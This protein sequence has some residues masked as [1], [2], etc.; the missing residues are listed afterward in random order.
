MT[1]TPRRLTLPLLAVP[2]LALWTGCGDPPASGDDDGSSTGTT[3]DTGDV[4][5]S[6]EPP[7]TGDETGPP[8]TEH[9]QRYWLHIDDTPPPPVVLEL[10]KEK[11]LEVFG[12]KAARNI[13]LIDVDS[14]PL[15]ADVLGRIQSSCGDK[16]DDYNPNTADTQLP[17]DPQ[18]DCGQ[19]PLGKTFGQTVLEWKQSP[20]YQMVRL[21]TM[22]PRNAQVRGTVMEDMANLFAS[23]DNNFGQLSFQ[24]ALAAIMFCPAKPGETVDACRDKMK[25]NNPNKVELHAQEAALHTRPFI[26]V[27]LLA[28]TL[29]LTLLATH[30]NIANDE[31][32]LAV[33]LYDALKDMQPL[34]EVYGPQGDHPGL[35]MPDDADFT[36]R[37]DALT[38][39]FKMTATAA[40]NLRRVEGIDASVG[41]GEMFLNAIAD[42][43]TTDDVRPPPLAFDFADEQKV[44]F[45]G[46]T[47]VPTVDMR[48]RITELNPGAGPGELVPVPSCE[49]KEFDGDNACMQ[50]VPGNDDPAFAQYVWQQPKWSLE[51]IIAHAAHA[52]YGQRKL[53]LCIIK[54]DPLCYLGAYIGVDTPTK[55]DPDDKNEDPVLDGV[56]DPPGWTYLPGLFQGLTFPAP[57]YFHEMLLNVAQQSLHDFS[58][59]P[60]PNGNTKYADGIPEIDEGDLNPVFALKGVPIGLTAADMIKSIRSELAKQSDYI[61]GVILGKYWKN[62]A[63]LDFYYRRATAVEAGGGAPMLFF[64]GPSDLR[65]S[66]DDP[67]AISNY[68]Y[69]KPGFFADR[70]LT[71]KVSRTDIGGLKDSEHEKYQLQPGEQTLYMQDDEARNYALHF[72]VPDNPDP[73]EI[74]LRIEPL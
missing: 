6:G 16:W 8:T 12:E 66:K 14:G 40:S 22:T 37:S 67:E 34:S 41:A 19:T 32:L 21:L 33:T 24:D 72:F 23:N 73:T 11:A 13:H 5:T 56:A 9:A 3:G 29:R 30:P 68:G 55:T 61:A 45:E 60:Q 17:A 18:H 49:G 52:A 53:D 62:N 26:D 20:E 27:S 36:T 25:A 51:Y 47:D 35:L 28:D 58:G 7:T 42:E 44:K 15:I 1:S 70:E 63:R 57:Q 39:Q 59:P 43:D 10:D 4:P 64:V 38:D 46:L 2:L 74:V 71:D 50:N 69:A 54:L 65:P 48:M 31:G